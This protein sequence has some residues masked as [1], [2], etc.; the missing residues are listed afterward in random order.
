[1]LQAGKWGRVGMRVGRFVSVLVV[2]AGAVVLSCGVALS[3]GAA[4]D[5]E[6]PAATLSS[7]PSSEVVPTDATTTDDGQPSTST[8]AATTDV[9]PVA[10]STSTSLV[11]ETS[12]T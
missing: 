2:G 11:E 8:S 1:M 5:G 12:T 6:A 10:D 9:S 3:D 7:I 4:D